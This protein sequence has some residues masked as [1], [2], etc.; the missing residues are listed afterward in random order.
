MSETE[1]AP[2][3]SQQLRDTTRFLPLSEIRQ[4]RQRRR[5]TRDGQGGQ[6]VN[7]WQR[8]SP[9]PR[10]GGRGCARTLAWPC[11]LRTLSRNP[12]HETHRPTVSLNIIS[13]VASSCGYYRGHIEQRAAQ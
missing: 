2:Y 4:R 8:R 13:L 12:S 3:P 11:L 7:A 5:A 10:R 9:C 6:A 1:N